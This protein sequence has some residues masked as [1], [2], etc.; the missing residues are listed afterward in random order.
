MVVIVVSNQLMRRE[1]W[2]KFWGYEGTTVYQNL[3][4]F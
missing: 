3:L 2:L 4:K 1:V